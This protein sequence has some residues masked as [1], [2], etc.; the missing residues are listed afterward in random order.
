VSA[1]VASEQKNKLIDKSAFTSIKCP[2]EEN[3]GVVHLQEKFNEVVE[4]AKQ[5]KVQY[6]HLYSVLLSEHKH[7]T[8]MDKYTSSKSM[9]SLEGYNNK[10]EKT[11][12]K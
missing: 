1:L 8:Q 4:S 12:N 7:L 5:S 6:Q 9:V 11:E 2:T 3:V 10:C